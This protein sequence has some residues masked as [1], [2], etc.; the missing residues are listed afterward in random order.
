MTFASTD[1]RKFNFYQRYVWKAADFTNMQQWIFEMAQGVF[2]GALG[3]AVLQG[4][5]VTLTSGLGVAV[6]AGICVAP[7]GRLMVLTG[8]DT[9]TLASPSGN[10]AFSLVVA[11]PLDVQET[12][13]PDP[14][15]PSITDQLHVGQS[16]Q[17]VVINGTP[18]ASPSYPAVLSTDVILMGFQLTTAQTTLTSASFDGSVISR[19]KTHYTTDVTTQ[20]SGVP[21]GVTRTHY[22]M[23]IPSG[24]TFLV[25]GTFVGGNTTSLGSIT[26]NGLCILGGTTTNS[27]TIVN[28]ATI[29]AAY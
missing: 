9:A 13:I 20:S 26:N 12:P 21:L 23:T 29:Q 27:G 5:A 18:A 22:Q 14:I 8:S 24:A 1:Y 10:P 28:N 3:G 7:N 6:A 4:S 15:N 11:R 19:P 17:I 25:T 16:Y 2:E